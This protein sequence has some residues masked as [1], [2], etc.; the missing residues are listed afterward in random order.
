M[1]P[2][3][4]FIRVIIN[5][6]NGK[7]LLVKNEWMGLLDMCAQ[8]KKITFK[9]IRTMSHDKEFAEKIK[10]IVNGMHGKREF[11]KFDVLFK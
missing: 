7:T 4:Q 9:V 10:D 2:N 1:S 11:I 3:I 5:Q 8:L 6:D